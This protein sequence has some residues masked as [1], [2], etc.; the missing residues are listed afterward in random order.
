MHI[1]LSAYHT[2]RVIILINFGKNMSL[3]LLRICFE[4]DTKINRFR[5]FSPFGTFNKV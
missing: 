4:V 3:Y 2:K 1:I 5:Q